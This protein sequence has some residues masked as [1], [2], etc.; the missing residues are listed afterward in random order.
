M[1]S[2]QQLTRFPDWE[3]CLASSGC[4]CKSNLCQ[5]STAFEGCGSDPFDIVK[6]ISAQAASRSPNSRCSLHSISSVPGLSSLL[7][8]NGN[9]ALY[10]PYGSI[11]QSR[12]MWNPLLKN[13]I[14]FWLTA[15]CVCVCVSA[16]ISGPHPRVQ[17]DNFL[18]VCR[19]HGHG[20][21]V[22]THFLNLLPR[23]LKSYAW[24]VCVKC[25]PCGSACDSDISGTDSLRR[26]WIVDIPQNCSMKTATTSQD[27]LKEPTIVHKRA[28]ILSNG[29]LRRCTLWSNMS[30]GNSPD[31]Q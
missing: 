2:K 11:L 30:A 19:T 16:W 6:S 27:A 20:N 15:V 13:W 14:A 21:G 29:K 31:F 3:I 12:N 17:W 28:E 18:V 25:G 10:N 7:S 8:W 26:P 23:S 1:A 4:K 5:H 9:N 24:F 22:G